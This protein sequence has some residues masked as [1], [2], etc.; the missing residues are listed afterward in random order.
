MACLCEM[1]SWLGYHVLLQDGNAQQ[2]L[3]QVHQR[4]ACQPRH[5]QCLKQVP[6]SPCSIN[7]IS[8]RGLTANRQQIRPSG[9]YSKIQ[10]VLIRH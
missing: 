8:H 1:N 10:N 9:G 7:L 6:L 2:S 5:L 4:G 3:R